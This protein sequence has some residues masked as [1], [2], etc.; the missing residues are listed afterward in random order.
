[1]KRDIYIKEKDLT[2]I[3]QLVNLCG[4]SHYGDKS[5]QFVIQIFKLIV[6]LMIMVNL[7]WQIKII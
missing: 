5:E 4:E 3:S 7:L 2:K 1:M 6:I